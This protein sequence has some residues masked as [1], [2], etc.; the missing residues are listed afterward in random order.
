MV[1][2]RLSVTSLVFWV[3]VSWLAVPRTDRKFRVVPTLLA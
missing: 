1:L 2:G 3:T